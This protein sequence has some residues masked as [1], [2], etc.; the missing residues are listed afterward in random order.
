MYEHHSQT[1]ENLRNLLEPDPNNLAL[2]I[3]GSVARGEAREDSDVDFLRVVPEPVFDE[4]SARYS[5]GMDAS[6]CCV[7]PGGGCGG[8]AI[9][10]TMLRNLRDRGSELQRWAFTNAQILFSR[11]PEIDVLAK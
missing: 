10:K 5:I 4:L 2:I 3:V 1:I 11:D 9:S 8:D 7:A 6:S